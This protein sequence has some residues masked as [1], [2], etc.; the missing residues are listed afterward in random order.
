M[1]ARNISA[2][3]IAGGVLLGACTATNLRAQVSAYTFTQEV[4]TWTPIGGSGTPLGMPGL[5]PPF[6]FDDNSFVTQGE[7]LPMGSSPTGNGWPI[8]FT[9]HFNGQ[10][11]DR[12]G[13]SMEGWLAFG[14]S[15]NGINAV[16]VPVGN[17]AYTP[18]SSPVPAEI[19]MLKRNR[20]AGFSLD[21]A[22]GGNT[23]PIQIRTGGTA[24]NRIF[25]AEW[26]VT[27][28]GGSNLLSFQIRL[29]ESG[30]DPAAQLVQV[31]FGT[32]IQ[33][34]AITGQVGLGGMDPS[35][36]NNRAVTV[37]PYDWQ[38]SVSGTANTATGRLPSLAANIPQGLTFTWSPPA[39]TV[40]GI[41][42]A[43]L[44]IDGAS[45]TGD[46][47][48]NAVQGAVDYDY[49]ITTGGP[50]L[51]PVAS[52]STATTS[53]PLT[54]LPQDQQ[55]Y[56]YVRADCGS[57]A[58]V[59]GVGHPFTTE[60]MIQVVCG[61]APLQFDH[62]YTDL[63][64]RTWYYTGSTNAPLRLIIHEGTMH[65]GD[66]L[67]IYDGPTDQAPLLFSS[68]NGPIAGQVVNSTGNHLTMKLVADDVGSC[69][70]HEFINPMAWEVGCLDCDPVLAN[71]QVVDDCENARF[72][73][74]VNIFSLGSSTSVSIVN[75]AGLPAVVANGPG[76][77]SVGPFTNGTPVLVTAS[78]AQNAYC[79]SAMELINGTC[80][81]VDCGPTTYTQCYGN[82]EDAR[83]A[84]QGESAGDR[85]AIRFLSGSLAAG[86]QLIVYDGNDEIADPVLGTVV[87]GDLTD[88]TFITSVFSNTIMLQLL[89]D[90]SGS[91]TSGAATPW[92]YVVACYDGCDAPEATFEVVNDCANGRFNVRVDLTSLG[93][94]AQ[95]SIT[96]DRGVAATTAS[97]TGQYTVGPFTNDADV[98]ITIH[99]SN[100]ICSLTSTALGDGCGVGLEELDEARLGIYPDPSEGA[101]NVVI[102]RG[103]GG[104][105]EV[106]VLDLS[107]RR[108]L[109]E[110]VMG[111]GGQVIPLSLDH[112]P[113][114]SYVVILR[115]DVQVASAT[116]RVMR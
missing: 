93:S 105:T 89:S 84:Y 73:V 80:P 103:F 11:Y 18:L 33:T 92:N 65:G 88:R 98:V 30:G 35:D 1:K 52:G 48:W 7:S 42:V 95:V 45:I 64:Q 76:A 43:G 10:P 111:A 115:S 39:C 74:G 49:I 25:V 22:A 37:S 75:D 102:P 108:V 44:A 31:V 83:W 29:H 14:H 40:T 27:R 2:W 104:R 38:A 12:V 6:T 77:Y 20:V 99:G 68:A 60:G 3:T 50:E 21:L 96:N 58:G 100:D 78:H 62:C 8:G 28:S 53:V 23:W 107:G 85:V 86:D 61:S 79:N 16:Y 51:P 19:D 59:W 9:F 32:M 116:V 91:C 41:T 71:F 57:G 106:E 114:G 34:A 69:A 66:L 46:L 94:A 87:G 63:E 81:V 112:V 36:F 26:N 90:G 113:A 17:T 15:S 56:A 5:P 67:T 24:P 82:D 109:L 97:A 47:T 55:L 101:F 72:T 70:V 54:G 110:R 13:L 4:G